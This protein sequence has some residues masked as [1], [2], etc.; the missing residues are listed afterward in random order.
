ML[1]GQKTPGMSLLL[2]QDATG[3]DT[4]GKK[5]LWHAAMSDGSDRIHNRTRVEQSESSGCA[6][7]TLHQ[8]HWSRGKT[9]GYHQA[10]ELC[11]CAYGTIAER[12]RC[13][14]NM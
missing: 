4:P 5:S 3:M 10:C 12:Q 2:L 7:S 8:L 11:G 6:A 9:R 1:I 13:S 14:E